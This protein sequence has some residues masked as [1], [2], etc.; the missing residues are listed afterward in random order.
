LTARTKK[1]GADLFGS[2]AP[3]KTDGA[4]SSSRKDA[5]QEAG[6]SDLFSE[7]FISSS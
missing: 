7:F 6:L 2:V 3:R 1:V 4:D 5:A